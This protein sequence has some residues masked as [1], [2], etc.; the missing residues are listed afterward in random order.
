MQL[1]NSAFK[2]VRTIASNPLAILME[3]QWTILE[4]AGEAVLQG[5]SP[6]MAAESS[7]VMC[8]TLK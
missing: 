2:A 1:L 8:R 3:S 5:D 4:G 7:A 6:H